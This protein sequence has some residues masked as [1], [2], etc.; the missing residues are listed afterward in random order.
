MGAPSA[1]YQADLLLARLDRIPVWP[2]GRRL[3]WVIGG[4]YFFAFFDVV[5]IGAALPVISAQFDVS[6]GAAS[7]AVTSSLAGYVVGGF[8][9][10]TFSDLRGRRVSMMVSV[11]LFTMGSVAAALSPSLAWLI[12]FR[13]VA[14]MGIGAEIACVTTYIAELA[15]AALRGRYTSWV[16][17]MAFTGFAV[18]P[19]AARGLVP[20]F[21]AG[22]RV[23]FALGALGGL[24]ILLLRRNV[25]LSARWLLLHG[26][27]EEAAREVEKAEAKARALLGHELPPP[28]PAHEQRL[29]TRWPARMLLQRE[30]IA[31]LALF[32]VIW[33]V[34]YLGNYG[35]LTLAPT[36][37][38]EHGY[39]LSSSLTYLLVTGFGFVVGALLSAQ[40]SDGF[41]R[42]YVTALGALV[43]A[44][45]LLA[46]GLF[47]SAAV[48]ITVG[49]VAS[50]SVGFLVP[51]LYT[52]TA[53]QFATRARATGVALTDGHVGGALAPTV[54]LAANSVW[55]FRG[56]FA[57][58]A[59]TG[60]VTAV[61]LCFGRRT[62]HTVLR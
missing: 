20:A 61:L 60:L 34:Y 19:I 46:I 56:A 55:S 8:A 13:F 24:S 28:G 35:W 57:V 59:A 5:A 12:V 11:G 2:Y 7:L 21:P 23:L 49:F 33:F 53:E 36:L 18:V 32:V 41:E 16:T 29:V 10:S 3:L 39:S 27:R 15:P 30:H 51:V 40:L 62:T 43:W 1:S 42:R 31:R 25:P 48:V 52:Y 4:G 22:W 47:T 50:A 44:A 45:A 6:T 58:M 37:L 38:V 9:D 26:R 17:V 14:G 54:L